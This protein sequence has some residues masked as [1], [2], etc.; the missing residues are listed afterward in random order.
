MCDFRCVSVGTILKW[1]VLVEVC[2]W[3]RD[4]WELCEFIVYAS[5]IWKEFEGLLGNVLENGSEETI[6]E[7]SSVKQ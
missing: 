4:R 1:L 2:F 6:F 3:K 5:G 7:N